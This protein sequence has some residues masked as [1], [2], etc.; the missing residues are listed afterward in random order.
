[1][2]RRHFKAIADTLAR[3]A[4]RIPA[5]VLWDL[6]NELADLCAAENPRFDRQ[7]FRTA[8]GLDA[9]ARPQAADT[10]A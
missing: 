8:C 3:F 10:A 5:P 7:R 2:T 9:W 1:M 4:D 6:A